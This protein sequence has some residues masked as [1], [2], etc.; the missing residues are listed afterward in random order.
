MMFYLEE[1]VNMLLGSIIVH[2][3]V[4]ILP[5][6]VIDGVHDICHFLDGQKERK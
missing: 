2:A 5:H 1:L 3:G 6:H 4:G